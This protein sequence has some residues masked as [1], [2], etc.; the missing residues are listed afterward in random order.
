MA[1]RSEAIG[2][3]KFGLSF[4]QICVYVTCAKSTITRLWEKY[5]STGSVKDRMKSGR[6]KALTTRA[7]RALVRRHVFSPFKPASESAIEFGI[8]QR[9]TRRILRKYCLHARRPFRGP[10]LRPIRLISLSNSLIFLEKLIFVL[11]LR[12]FRRPV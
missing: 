12:Y 6:P 1:R 11:L 7:E 10:V 2:M 8:S 5:Q 4:S 3:L 9:T